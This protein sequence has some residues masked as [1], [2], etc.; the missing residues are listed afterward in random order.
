MMAGI[1]AELLVRVLFESGASHSYQINE[2]ASSLD[3]LTWHEPQA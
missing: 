3:D 2:S 1:L